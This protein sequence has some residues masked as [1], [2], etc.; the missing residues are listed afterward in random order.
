VATAVVESSLV[1]PA[2]C[3]SYPHALAVC[4]LGSQEELQQARDND[5]KLR[6]HYAD[7]GFV[8]PE[9]LKAD[10]LFYVSYRMGSRIVWTSKPLLVRAGERILK[11][12]YGNCLRGRCGNRLSRVP[13]MPAPPVL[14]PE[15]EHEKP[16]LIAGLIPFVPEAA[17]PIVPFVPEAPP[18]GLLPLPAPPPIETPPIEI[19]PIEIP[20][21][22][23]PPI[24]IVP[25]I[26]VPPAR[27]GTPV[28]PVRAPILISPVPEPEAIVLVAAGLILIC[29]ARL[30]LR[31]FDDP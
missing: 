6:E 5:P 31:R 2:V 28:P 9:I 19:P 21:G 15:I 8:R 27:G 20:A 29:A 30:R 17:P 13:M 24:P 1:S 14:P 10:E 11:D 3:L 4:G 26:Y 18:L 16:V 22:R 7:V 23:G 25:P 12:R